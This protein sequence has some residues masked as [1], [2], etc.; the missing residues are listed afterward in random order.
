VSVDTRT[1]LL[2]LLREHLG[3]TGPKKG[4]AREQRGAC[5]V[6]RDGEDQAAV[7]PPAIAQHATAIV[8]VEG[9]AADHALHP[10]RRSFITLH[11]AGWEV[12][13]FMLDKWIRYRQSD[14]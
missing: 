6:L 14:I 2:D 3:I 8:T 11:C 10:L 5:T 7:Y 12:H 4:C 13:P 1:R 9:L